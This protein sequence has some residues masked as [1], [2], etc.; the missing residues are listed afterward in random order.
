MAGKLHYRST[1]K[2]ISRNGGRAIFFKVLGATKVLPVSKMALAQR[3]NATTS[4]LGSIVWTYG[5][6]GDGIDPQIPDG[7]NFAPLIRG[8]IPSTSSVS[9]NRLYPAL[10]MVSPNESFMNIRLDLKGLFRE[11]K[12]VFHFNHYHLDVD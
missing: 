9:L 11:D 10:R 6:D 7:W 1:G 4:D 12:G 3:V 2:L 8:E 5:P